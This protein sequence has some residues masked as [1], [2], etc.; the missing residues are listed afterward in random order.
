MIEKKLKMTE[1]QANGYSYES[2]QWI[3]T[4]PGFYDFQKSL[5]SYTWD[6]RSLSI[7]RVNCGEINLIYLTL[8]L[9]KVKFRQYKLM[10]KNWKMTET[11][12]HGYSYENTRQELSN[13]YQHDRV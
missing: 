9:L 1:T 10:K 8:I 3:P 13:E 4:W 2:T 5:R 12:T 6:E 11:L 7:V